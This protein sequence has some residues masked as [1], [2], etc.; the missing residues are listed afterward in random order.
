VRLLEE[1]IVYDT[2]RRMSSYHSP[3]RSLEDEIVNDRMSMTTIPHSSMI[4][5][6]GGEIRYDT[7]SRM[8]SYNSPVRSQDGEI[9]YMIHYEE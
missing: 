2:S 5:G 3:L 9:L 6:G 4:I 7:S 1:D 8:T